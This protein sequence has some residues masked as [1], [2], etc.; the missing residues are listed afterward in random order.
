MLT[1]GSVLVDDFDMQ[2]RA[3][4]TYLF[5]NPECVLIARSPAEVADVLLRLDR[6][7]SSGKYAAGYLGYEAGLS[8]DKPIVSRHTHRLPLVWL[9]I[10][11]DCLDL[12]YHHL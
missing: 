6:E 11:D 3:G 12:D 5:R 7:L 8:L 9:G 2:A 4:R 10:Y 1:A